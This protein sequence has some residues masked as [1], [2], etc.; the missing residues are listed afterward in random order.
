V[1]ETSSE[2]ATT[3]IEISPGWGREQ[4]NHVGTTL[5]GSK[6][7]NRDTLNLLDAH[8]PTCDVAL[9]EHLVIAAADVR[10]GRGQ[11]RRAGARDRGAPAR[12]RSPGQLVLT[13]TP[14]RPDVSAGVRDVAFAGMGLSPLTSP[15]PT[16]T[17]TERNAVH[18]HP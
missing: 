2:R 8:L 3:A 18:V 1:I 5:V 9:T 15:R 17:T 4:M 11:S 10:S 6:S 7:P 12:R 14:S 16:R 13:A